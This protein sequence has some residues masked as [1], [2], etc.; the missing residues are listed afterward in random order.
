[1][2]TL[3]ARNGVWQV[4]VPVK[5]QGRRRYIWRSLRTTDRGV[6]QQAAAKFAMEVMFHE[7]YGLSLFPRKVTEVIDAWLE[8][9]DLTPAMR[10]AA[11]KALRYWRE[12]FGEKLITELGDQ[13]DYLPWRRGYW[14]RKSRD[15]KPT[16]SANP[17]DRTLV[18]EIQT[19]RR[20]FAFAKRRGM[21]AVEPQLPVMKRIKR[22]RRPALTIDEQEQLKVFLDSSWANTLHRQT[23]KA[24][25]LTLLMTGIRVG[26]AKSLRW[27]DLERLNLDGSLGSNIGTHS[28]YLLRVSGKTGEREVVAYQ[29]LINVLSA[30]QCWR[31]GNEVWRGERSLIFSDSVGNPIGDIRESWHNVCRQA[32]IGHFALYCLR[33]TYI[34][35]HLR[36][37]ESP[38]IYMLARNCGTSVEMIEKFYSHVRTRDAIQKLSRRL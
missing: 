15:G 37:A 24:M 6:A 22:N 19:M 5:K 17:A 7:R 11:W 36:S 2:A 9:E 25:I 26:E 23:V 30:Y 12:W 4:R 35:N 14:K 18:L 3:F 27:G 38:D 32:G 1:M 16:T 8:E 10:K 33:H 13:S 31:L 21:I 29:E 28:T 34:T 20:V